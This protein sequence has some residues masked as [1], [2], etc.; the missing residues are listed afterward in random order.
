MKLGFVGTGDITDAIVTGLSKT[1]FAETPIHLSPRNT[2]IS[3]HLAAS[4]ANV[5][6]GRDNQDVVDNA[7]MV[8]LA[9]RPQVAEE[10]TRALRFRSGQHVVSVVAATPLEQV[11]GWIGVPVRLTQA[12]PLPFVATLNGATAIYPP[13]SEVAALFSALGAAIEVESKA[14][15]DLL[16]TAS[17]LMGTYFGILESS[18][19][20]LEQKGLAYENGRAYLNQMFS[21]LA[22]AGAR[23]PEKTFE[24]MRMG[25]S[26]KGGLNEQVF[27][28]FKRDGGTK[29]LTDA[30]DGVFER[31]TK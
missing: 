18:T 14:E 13:D 4:F 15:Y 27:E 9:I 31:I 22:D 23:S 17:A 12:I 21:A 1:K 3:A 6:V 30:L 19:R 2:A 26:T 5:T 8:F 16:G 10:V 28:D 7:D 25:Y 20:W 24:T 29:A 11:A